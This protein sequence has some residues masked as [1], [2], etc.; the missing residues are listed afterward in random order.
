M[1]EGRRATCPAAT[2]A[3]QFPLLPDASPLSWKYLAEGGVHLV[4]RYVG[5]KASLRGKV[6]KLRKRP[7]AV[8][9]E[10][11]QEFCALVHALCE[12]NETENAKGEDSE[13]HSADSKIQTHAQGKECKQREQETSDASGAS[14]SHASSSSFS[15]SSSSL[16]SDDS[17]GCPAS[18]FRLYGLI[19]PRF[20]SRQSLFVL[21]LRSADSLLSCA[22]RKTPKRVLVSAPRDGDTEAAAP[23]RTPE[24]AR[25]RCCTIGQ[26]VHASPSWLEGTGDSTALCPCVVEDDF[27]GVP[28]PLRAAFAS[29]ELRG[30]DACQPS[31]RARESGEKVG[32]CGCLSSRCHCLT[33]LHGEEEASPRAIGER[34]LEISSFAARYFSVELKPKC[35]LFEDDPS[36]ESGASDDA[37]VPA[38]NDTPLSTTLP[39]KKHTCA[40]KHNPRPDPSKAAHVSPSSSSSSVSPSS[41]SSLSSSSPSAPSAP[42]PSSSSLSSSSSSLSVCS[43]SSVSPSPPSAKEG[44]KKKR[45]ALP[46][47]FAMQQFLKLSRG[48]IP[49]R[50]LFDPPRLFRCTYTAFRSEIA[51]LAVAPQN[52][53]AVFLDGRP[54]SATALA[55]CG[56]L[57]RFSAEEHAKKKRGEMEG[58]RRLTSGGSPEDAIEGKQQV[59]G[60]RGEHAREKKALHAPLFAQ[61]ESETQV[62]VGDL[63][64]CIWE[65]AKD[66]FS[67]ILLLQAFAASQQRLAISL[68]SALK[69][70]TAGMHR[71]FRE[72]YLL[73]SFERYCQAVTQ[74][75]ALLK[76]PVA[77]PTAVFS[78]S[79][80]SSSSPSSSPLASSSSSSSSSSF[81]P[82]F[83]SVGHRGFSSAHEA[84][85]DLQMAHAKEGRRV[86]AWLRGLTEKSRPSRLD[87]PALAFSGETSVQISEGR[88]S[89]EPPRGPAEGSTLF[90]CGDN[91]SYSGKSV[92]EEQNAVD[93]GFAWLTRYLVGRAFMDASIMTNI[94]VT[95]TDRVVEE[96]ARA[97]P[98]S[99]ASSLSRFRRLKGLPLRMQKREV[100]S[101]LSA[102]TLH[103]NGSSRICRE[104]LSDAQEEE[105]KEMSE[106]GGN[107]A[108]ERTG[109]GQQNGE[110]RAEETGN[111]DEEEPGHGEEN[112]REQGHGEEKERGEAEELQRDTHS[113]V[114][115]SGAEGNRDRRWKSSHM[116]E[117]QSD[118]ESEIPAVFYRLSLVDVDFKSDERIEM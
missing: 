84:A 86:V 3:L 107:R 92:S 78:S 56:F 46:S 57:L 45:S 95:G 99:G 11:V 59:C 24:A 27:V 64:A 106:R 68:A 14:R 47:R 44:R 85:Q 113:A 111:K 43:S 103:T 73:T 69:T 12:R 118:R 36:A 75:L 74:G 48:T 54:V 108:K 94:I 17:D 31:E 114:R 58:S 50:S 34:C 80:V 2:S 104:T 6:L 38:R 70:A 76:D 110:G 39:Q 4:F 98:S 77:A 97:S 42:S 22:R 49:A 30:T 81:S 9:W 117:L 82:S 23:V 83:L 101:S 61:G 25:T 7:H 93:E 40:H 28:P 91:V 33:H 109:N 65:E 19:S 29:L 63:L 90:F 32:D 41:P 116:V 1:S 55:D 18:R 21:P 5:E 67:S 87:A 102:C 13:T 62:D 72:K 16:S 37:C 66:L 26:E 79:V 35:G 53:F 112:E 89:S 15:S 96:I 52:N 8:K 115:S 71:P 100:S 20:L 10:L 60:D 51:H 105:G 88:E